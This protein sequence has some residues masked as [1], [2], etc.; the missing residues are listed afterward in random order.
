MVCV[1]S[2]GHILHHLGRGGI[3]RVSPWDV[4]HW[5]SEGPANGKRLRETDKVEVAGGQ[6]LW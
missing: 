2:L 5:K 3:E 4:G 1:L 6:L